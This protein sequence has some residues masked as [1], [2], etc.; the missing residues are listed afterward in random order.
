[1]VGFSELAGVAV[2]V[3]VITLISSLAGIY[4]ALKIPPTLVL[5]G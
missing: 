5:A 1:V 2:L 4:R 3:T